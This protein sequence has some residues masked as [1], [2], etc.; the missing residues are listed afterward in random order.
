MRITFIGSG[1]VA[2][3]LARAA[4]AAGHTVCQ[5]MSREYDHAEAL[6]TT[7]GAEAIDAL[8]RVS[9]EADVYVL[10]VSD[11]S[12]YDL[13]LELR[14]ERKLVVHTSGTVP[15]NVLKP[16]SRH[17]GVMW[18][19]QTFIRSVEMDYSH[20]P[21]CIEASD[22]ISLAKL[23]RLAGSISDK[24]YELNAEQRK[25]LHLASVMVNNFGNALNAI[26]QDYLRKE[27]IPFEILFPII[28]MT[29]Q[30]IYHGDLWKL[31]SGPAARRDTRTIDAHR[32]MLA[33]DKDLLDLYDIM[34]KF[35]D[36]ATH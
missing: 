27:D 3:H 29:A 26:A 13:A 8:Q 5:V 1:N 30:K 9:M 16:M 31:Q 12:L 34:T 10:A 7:V 14:L 19:P 22:A 20:L 25:K 32:R 36:H 28:E 35:I 2:T 33:D 18:A 23:K 11:D 4:Q 24:C 21:F 15:I 17:H 6:A